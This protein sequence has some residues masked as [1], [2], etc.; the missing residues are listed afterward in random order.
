[1]SKRRA[2]RQ[3]G[4]RTALPLRLGG[5]QDREGLHFPFQMGDLCL[6]AFLVYVLSSCVLGGGRFIFS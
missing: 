1:M 4:N 6:F 5:W 3:A 2:L